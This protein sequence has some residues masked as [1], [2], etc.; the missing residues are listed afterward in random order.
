MA[1]VG[2]ILASRQNEWNTLHNAYT[3]LENLT[4]DAIASM[5]SSMQLTF[6]PFPS[7]FDLTLRHILGRALQKLH[8]SHTAK[9]AKTFLRVYLAQQA[10]PC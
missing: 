6:R 5:L 10:S 7:I 9:S 8:S 2:T 4:D 3:A 1:G